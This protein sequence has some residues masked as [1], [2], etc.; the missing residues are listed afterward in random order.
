MSSAGP[1]RDTYDYTEGASA[2]DINAVLGN[3]RRSRRDSQRSQTP[4]GEDGEG[5]MFD[6]PGHSAIPSSVS[7]MSHTERSLAGRRSSEWDARKRGSHDSGRPA[8]SR[9]NSGGS[10]VSNGQAGAVSGDEEE[11]PG[12]E[13]S[14]GRGRRRKRRSSPPRSTV[15]GNLA[16]LFGR[17]PAG[18]QSRRPSTSQ[19]SSASSR[20]RWSRY[21]DPGSDYA[22][23]T[24]DEGEERWGYSSGEEDDEESL[25]GDAVSQSDADYRSYQASP[26]SDSLPLLSV[27]PIFVDEVRID[28]DLPLD[29]LD[30]PP[31]GPP[32]RQTIYVPDEDNTFRFVGFETILWR[33]YLWRFA[34]VLSFGIL[35][36]LGHWFPRIWLRWVAKEKAFVSVTHGFVVVEVSSI[37]RLIKLCF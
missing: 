3:N 12:D 28:M 4:Y 19:R 29:T 36:L 25:H 24:D 8:H 30:P 31:P 2:I 14:V 18:E 5:K 35:G 1:S 13:V 27:D 21:S 10:V 20:S 17:N 32:S 22:I 11:G 6:G 7:R 37:P 34:C 23:E 26:E 9:R 33:Q 15:F 16:N